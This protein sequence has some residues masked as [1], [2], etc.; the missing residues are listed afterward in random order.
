MPEIPVNGFSLYFED[1]GAG[2]PVLLSHSLV[3]DGEMFAYQARALAEAGFRVLNVDTRGHG[4]SGYPEAERWTLEEMVEDFVTLLDRLGV[5]A[6]HWV[7]L[8]LGGMLGLRMA[9]QHPERVRS[10]VLMNTTG[11]AEP[12]E[13]RQRYLGMVQALRAHGPQAVVEPVLQLFF[14][15]VTFETKPELVARW[16]EKILAIDRE[17]V[18]RAA[19]ATFTR[20]DLSDRLGEVQAPALVITGEFDR[21]RPRPESEFLAQKLNAPL[22]VI[23]AAAH[24]TAL[25]QPEGTTEAILSFLRSVEG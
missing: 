5:E 4:R 23:P 18:A 12:P 9:L 20:T 10:L 6:V 14:A 21:A 3:C 19:E 2:P 11:Q 22:E 17:G 13:S 7:G 16:R 8:S 24:L 15:P 1:R 25:E